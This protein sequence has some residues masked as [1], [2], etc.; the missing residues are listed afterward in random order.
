MVLTSF[1]GF[2]DCTEDLWYT[3]V[4]CISYRIIMMSCGR[5]FHIQTLKPQHAT[6]IFP[7]LKFHP[8]K[9]L[10]HELEWWHGTMRCHE[11]LNGKRRVRELQAW[12]N[13][14]WDYGQY[15]KSQHE[16]VERCKLHYYERLWLKCM[17]V[18]ARPYA[19][20][21]YCLPALICCCQMSQL[22][23]DA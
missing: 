8:H 5:D 4:A 13:A 16:R 3:R 11:F 20:C 23:R 6:I 1:P 19:F 12:F 10:Q 7:S 22:L 15:K 14:W 17:R 18:Y 2:V 9:D 21:S